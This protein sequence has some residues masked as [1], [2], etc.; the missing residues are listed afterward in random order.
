MILFVGV[1]TLFL[2][3]RISHG[4]VLED[5]LRRDIFAAKYYYDESL[6]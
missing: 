5:L 2:Y 4:R 3:Q 1:R 6:L